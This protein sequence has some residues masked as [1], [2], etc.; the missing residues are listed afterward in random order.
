[1]RNRALGAPG[2]KMSEIEP[3]KDLL[4]RLAS[5]DSKLEKLLTSQLMIKREGPAEILPE[6]DAGGSQELEPDPW[7]DAD[8]PDAAFPPSP[9]RPGPAISPIEA[10]TILQKVQKINRDAEL[11]ERVI[12]LEKQNRKINVLGA[13]FMTA[14]VLIFVVFTILMVPANVFQRGIILPPRQQVDS[15]KPSTGKERPEA[16]VPQPAEPIAKVEVPPAAGSVA[17]VSAA[18]PGEAAAPITDPK[19]AKAAAPVVYVGSVTSNKYHY[20]DCKWAAKIKPYKL[21]I[22]HSVKE[23]REKGYIPCPTCNPPRADGE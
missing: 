6:P 22:F 5:V 4:Q 8:I 18:K 11:I 1:M 14:V 21:R 2:G 15:A 12:K 20:P 9:F 10:D 23:A 7:E 13:M 16:K 17:P 3:L 19:N